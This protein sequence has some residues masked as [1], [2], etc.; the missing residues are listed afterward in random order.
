MKHDQWITSCDVHHEQ[1]PIEYNAGDKYI[2]ALSDMLAG[3][4]A[5]NILNS[6]INNVTNPYYI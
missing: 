2:S 3:F 5:D 4:V 1:Y 6:M